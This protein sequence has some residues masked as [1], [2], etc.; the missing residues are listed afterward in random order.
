MP[1]YTF[2]CENCGRFDIKLSVAERELKECPTCQGKVS[3]IFKPNRNFYSFRG[4]WFAKKRTTEKVHDLDDL[5]DPD[6]DWSKLNQEDLVESYKERRWGTRNPDPEMII[7]D[8]S[9]GHN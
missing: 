2:E 7:D 1:T 3:R 9:R 4:N 8:L 6:F 5:D